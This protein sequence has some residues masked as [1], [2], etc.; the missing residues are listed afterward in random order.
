[1]T[2]ASAGTSALVL[3]GA[4]IGGLL[5]G[6]AL[7]RFI[8]RMLGRKQHRPSRDDRHDSSRRPS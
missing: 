5:F 6:Y 8:A 2:L 7:R 1:M 3:M 4:G